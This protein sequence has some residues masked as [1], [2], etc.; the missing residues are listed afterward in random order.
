[1]AKTTPRAIPSMGTGLFTLSP[2]T[3]PGTELVRIDTPPLTAVLNSSRLAD[4]CAGC[5]DSSATVE[6]NPQELKECTRCRVVRYCGKNCQ[7]KDWRFAHSLECPI[8]A[9]LHPRILPNNVRAVLRIVLRLKNGKCKQDELDAFLKL[10]THARADRNDI[11]L[12]AK[13][14]KEY[15]GTDM[16]EDLIASFFTR[17][18]VNTF[19]LVAYDCTPIGLYLDSYSSLMNHSCDYNAIV[20]FDGDRMVVKATRPIGKDE[21]VFISY[22]DTTYCVTTRRRQLKE[23]YFFDCDCLKCTREL[24]NPDLAAAEAAEA[25]GEALI[26]SVSSSPQLQDADIIQKYKTGINTILKNMPSNQN[27]YITK[28]PFMALR[29]ELIVALINAGRYDDAW[30]QCA[31]EYFKID[32]LLYPNRGHP[33]R[34]MHAWRLAKITASTGQNQLAQRFNVDPVVVLLHVL[35]WLVDG[36]SEACSAPLLQAQIRSA[37]QGV[38]Q[39]RRDTRMGW[40]AVE[41]RLEHALQR[42]LEELS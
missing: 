34:R 11:V 6:G 3:T 14:V 16:D 41:E 20:V 18:E 22:I 4:T 25:A 24:E 15:S 10:N 7:L 28:Q 12:A 31:I 30:I 2:I 38:S 35:Q 21:Q 39:V 36:E 23:R 19:N 40:P 9:K 1:M 33:L 26:N 42:E 32:P 29:N 17:L 13:A 8:F 5:Y 37:Y 27:S